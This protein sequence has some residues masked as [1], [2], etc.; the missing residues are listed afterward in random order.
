MKDRRDVPEL[1]GAVRQHCE[2]TWH[3][4]DDY[5]RLH[6]HVRREMKGVRNLHAPEKKP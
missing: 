2:H 3:Q 5:V 4:G 6:Q 1:F